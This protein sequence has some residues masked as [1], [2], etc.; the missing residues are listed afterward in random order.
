MYFWVVLS[1]VFVVFLYLT[2]TFFAVRAA[3]T[4]R[5]SQGAV[6]W[7]VFLIATPFLAVPLYL[8]LGHH[9]LKR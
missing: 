8:F 2:A 9:K 4:A 1:T 6:G 7:V 5:T 3:Q